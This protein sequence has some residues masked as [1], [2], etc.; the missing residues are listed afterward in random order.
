[1]P[2][3][4]DPLVILGVDE[5][6]RSVYESLIGRPPA[7]SAELAGTGQS[8]ERLRDVLISLAGK[9]LVV[10]VP[11]DP[12]RF[13]AV[14]PDVAL[15][16]LLLDEEQRMTRAYEHIGDLAVRYRAHTAAPTGALTEFV[17]GRR[18]VDQRVDQLRRAAR[19]EL[20]VLEKAPWPGA[21][22]G[23]RAPGRTVYEWDVLAP[24][25]PPDLPESGPDD[26]VR[27]LPALPVRLYVVDDR[28]ALL[29]LG[30][31]EAAL[32]VHPS[33]LFDALA[34]LFEGLWARASPD[35]PP[36]QARPPATAPRA[37][38]QTHDQG[39]LVA[40][41]L[42]EVTDQAVAR[43]LGVGHRTMQRQI[44]TL[45]RELGASTR[46]QAGAQAALRDGF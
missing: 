29:P 17:A 25:G 21:P 12:V 22:P 35:R 36:G 27:T 16:V 23:R 39:R 46:F 44:A 41:L 11:G 38:Q 28:L 13:V 30:G 1:M 5:V 24:E 7:T 8:S 3:P 15:E 37:E 34:M 31:G 10:Q 32:V 42:S 45:M 40:L 14:A 6:E 4:G 43:Q 9:G 33:A 20:R 19:H 18:E 2:E 26:L